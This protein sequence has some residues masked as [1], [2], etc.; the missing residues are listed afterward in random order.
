[1]LVRTIN[2]GAGSEA[3]FQMYSAVG[4]E[5]G[6]SPHTWAV[7]LPTSDTTLAAVGGGRDGWRCLGLSHP[8]PVPET[9][10]ADLPGLL[11]VEAVHPGLDRGVR[12]EGDQGNL[13]A[14]VSAID[15]RRI[16][17][18]LVSRATDDY[19]SKNWTRWRQII[20]AAQ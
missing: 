16:C 11:R 19:E 17:V 5:C 13:V 3:F 7:T 18:D 8:Y 20:E 14:A 10:R 2:P 15:L 9:V 6:L 12:P 1:V 4:P